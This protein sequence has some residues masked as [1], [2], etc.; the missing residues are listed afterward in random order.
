M[1]LNL[2]VPD[3]LEPGEGTLIVSPFSRPVLMQM[4]RVWINFAEVVML[5][6]VGI[7]PDSPS[8]AHGL[9]SPAATDKGFR[10]PRCQTTLVW[11]FGTTK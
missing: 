8:R 2:P 10:T 11:H 1:T 7:G 4:H 5:A 9:G 6:R 3:R